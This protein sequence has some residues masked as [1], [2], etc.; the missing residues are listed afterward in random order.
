MISIDRKLAE[1][2]TNSIGFDTQ[3]IPKTQDLFRKLAE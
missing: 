2:N 3:G 1:L